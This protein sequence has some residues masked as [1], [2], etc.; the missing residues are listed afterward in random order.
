MF[1]KF[2][3]TTCLITM[4]V[5]SYGQQVFVRSNGGNTYTYRSMDSVILN[6]SD[7]DTVYLPG[8]TFSIGTVV[9][10]KK[11]VLYGAGHY[12]DS[13]AATGRTILNGEIRIIGTASGS[14]FQ[15][16]YLS[17]N[18]VFGTD[19]NNSNV[20]QFEIRRCSMADVIFAIN[21][22]YN[23]K[24]QFILIRENV[25][26]GN[27][28]CRYAKDILIEN[29]LLNGGIYYL[30]GSA[31]LANN[32]IFGNGASVNACASITLENNIF[33]QVS[34]FQINSS[35]NTYRNNVFRN[36]NPL[37]GSDI[38]EQNLFSVTNLFVLGGNSFDY[39]SNFNL[40]P[41]SPARTAGIGGTECG[42]FG[43]PRPYKVAAL[44]ANPHIGQKNIGANTNS[45]GQ[46]QVQVTVTAQNN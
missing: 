44:P 3:A 45:A 29:N 9:F 17:G 37:G 2:L 25:V 13:A 35:S 39:L 6:L 18:L 46:L 32:I 14:K 24:A 38:G 7:G 11:V 31:R 22:T 28:N 36:A 43:G 4:V 16:F 21:D 30:S 19:P 10:T 42:I 20:E 8:G 27:I 1:P 33:V 23:S 34:T 40:T 12:P 41:D 5:C 15:G 26:R